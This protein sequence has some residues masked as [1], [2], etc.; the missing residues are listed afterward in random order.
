MNTAIEDSQASW[1]DLISA[2]LR[3]KEL[4]KKFDVC[5]NEAYAYASVA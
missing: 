2:T 4:K 1:A 5:F 3:E